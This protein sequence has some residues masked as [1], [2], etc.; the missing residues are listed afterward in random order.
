MAM[1]IARIVAFFKS[2]FSKENL[3]RVDTL[4][5]RVFVIKKKE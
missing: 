5:L 3:I 2:R 1:T 4:G